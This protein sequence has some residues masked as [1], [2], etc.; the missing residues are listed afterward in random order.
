[1]Y[2]KSKNIVFFLILIFPLF[3]VLLAFLLNGDGMN[4]SSFLYCIMLWMLIFQR[5][6]YVYKKRDVYI[7]IGVAGVVLLSLFRE[8]GNTYYFGIQFANMILA[9][10]FYSSDYFDVSEFSGYCLKNEKLFLI[11]NLGVYLVLLMSYLKTGLY[12]GDMWKVDVFKGPYN[13]PHTLA[14]ILLFVA[15]LDVFYY[16]KLNKMIYLL[17]VGI[18]SGL[19]FLTAVRTVLVSLAILLVYLMIQIYKRGASIQKILMSVVMVCGVLVLWKSGI[20]TA[21]IE[22]SLYALTVGGDI[23]NSRGKIFYRSIEALF[24]SDYDFVHNPLWGI[25][26]SSLMSY[27]QIMLGV[28]I[29]AHNDIIN[30][31]TCYGIVGL[32]L[33]IYSFIRFSREKFWGITFLIMSLAVAN[34]LFSYGEAIPL[35]IYSRVLFEEGIKCKSIK[36][37]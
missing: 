11:V 6:G 12:Y 31:L 28:A 37:S 9:F 27:N 35:I 2:F 16:I 20:A 22:K 33:Y 32:G 25:G 4:S 30:A 29:Q 21:V 1:M 18:N 24:V 36:L 5:N 17:F 8:T 23:T 7:L 13:L 14:Y 19:I 26:M 3:N 15:V 34:G 10:I